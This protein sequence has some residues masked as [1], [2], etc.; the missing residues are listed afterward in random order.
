MIPI[1]SINLQTLIPC[2]SCLVNPVTHL[3]DDFRVAV[4]VAF[5]LAEILGR[6]ECPL[7]VLIICPEHKCQSMTHSSG[8]VNIHA[9]AKGF[10]SAACMVECRHDVQ[11]LEGQ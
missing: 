10:S 1:N 6:I 11:V 8:S 4:V 9:T 5:C 7:E 3:L 2:T